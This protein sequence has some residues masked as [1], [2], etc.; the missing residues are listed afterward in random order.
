MLL[1]HIRACLPELRTRAAAALVRARGELAKYGDALL[2]GK[3]NQGALMLQ[4]ITQ[5]ANNY[6]DAIDGTSAQV[7]GAARGVPCVHTLP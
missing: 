1:T 2:E 4:L 7:G 3:S 5:F 6:C